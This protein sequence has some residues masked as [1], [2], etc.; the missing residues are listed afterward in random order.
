[1]RK[2]ACAACFYAC[3]ACSLRLGSGT[4]RGHVAVCQ[5]L[6]RLLL[7]LHRMPFVL[8]PLAPALRLRNCARTWC[9]LVS[10]APPSPALGL[11][12]CAR[13]R[14]LLVSAY[15]A[16]SCVCV[17]CPL[18]LRRLLL[19]LGSGTARE[20]VACLSALAPPA[21][22]LRLRNCA[23][24]RCLLVSACAAYCVCFGKLG[25]FAPSDSALRTRAMLALPAQP[26]Y[27]S[28]RMSLC[29]AQKACNSVRG[30]RSS[31]F[32]RLRPP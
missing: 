6:R 10:A 18:C 30:G 4:A 20:H 27:R 12:N 31:H 32:L 3:A 7:R 26:A 13:T 17:A 25:C 21:P 15:A 11:R 24:T 23:R 9:L 1:M 19:R 14:C 2:V 28:L 29:L 5:R 16:C 8:V 22:A